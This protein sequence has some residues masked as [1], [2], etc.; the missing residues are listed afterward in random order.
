MIQKVPKGVQT[1]SNKHTKRIQQS[2]KN[3][4]KKIRKGSKKDPTKREP[5]RIQKGTK[6]N[7]NRI[8]KGPNEDPKRSQKGSKKDPKITSAC[9]QGL[10]FANYFL[11]KRDSRFKSFMKTEFSKIRKRLRQGIPCLILT[12]CPQPKRSPKRYFRLY[13]AISEIPCVCV[14][15][16]SRV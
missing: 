9:K 16:I 7:P 5:T 4:P 2:S 15:F 14:C 12:F 3:N 13:D 6:H 11:Q 8:Q 1:S 10:V